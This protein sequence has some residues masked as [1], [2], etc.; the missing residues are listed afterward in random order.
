MI[1]LAPRVRTHTKGVSDSA[2]IDFLR[3]MVVTEPHQIERFHALFVD[4]DRSHLGDAPMGLGE[5]HSLTLRMRELF[6]R[7]LSVRAAGILLA[8]NHP[9]GD[10]R[11]SRAD[12]LSTRKVEQVAKALDIELLDHLIFTKAAVFSMRA[13]VVHEYKSRQPVFSR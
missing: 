11:P 1:D 6:A 13:G 2:T 8:H 10:C 12:I 7:A 3:A 9:S 4:G 5:A